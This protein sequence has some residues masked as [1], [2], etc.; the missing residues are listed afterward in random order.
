MAATA[1]LY[2]QYYAVFLILALN[3]VFVIGWLRGKRALR[4]LLSW[5]TAQV[6]V[7]LLFLP[8]VWYAG[9]KLWTY[10]RFK[11]SVEQDLSLGLFPY[12]ARHLAAFTWGHAEGSLADWWWLGLVPLVVLVLCFVGYW[13]VERRHSSTVRHRPS[14]TLRLSPLVLLVVILGCGFV[15][16]LAAPFNPP[17][18]ERLLLLALPAYLTLVAA[19]LLALWPQRRTAARVSVAL[20][21]AAAAVSLAFFYTVPRYPEDDYRP[22]AERVG[23]LGLPTD[24]VLAVHPWQVGYLMSYIPDEEARPALVLTDVNMDGMM[25][26]EVATRLKEMP[27]TRHAPAQSRDQSAARWL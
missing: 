15:A 3:L 12:L 16:N 23:T 9:G 19:L 2:T 27:E 22:I 14:S 1:A 20:F 7:L 26:H 5:L 6:A 21:V 18:S 25:G 17:R 11:V 13:I 24:A 10:I 4:E 8:W